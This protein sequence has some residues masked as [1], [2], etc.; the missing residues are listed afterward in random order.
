MQNESELHDIIKELDFYI[1]YT[2]YNKSTAVVID[3][4]SINKV[5]AFIKK[6]ADEIECLMFENVLLNMKLNE[7]R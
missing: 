2:Q 3:V 5:K 7:R 6:Q 1:G 4:E